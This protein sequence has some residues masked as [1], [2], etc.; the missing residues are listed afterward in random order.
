MRRLLTLGIAVALACVAGAQGVMHGNGDPRTQTPTPN[1]AQSRFYVDDATGKLYQANSGSPCVWT[2]PSATV[3]DPTYAANVAAPP[4]NASGFIA[5]TV[6]TATASIGATTIPVANTSGFSIGQ[7]VIVG[8]GGTSNTKDFAAFISSVSFSSIGLSTTAVSGNLL[9]PTALGGTTGLLAAIQANW[10]VYSVGTTKLVSGA[11]IGATSITLGSAG[12]Y[13]VGQGLLIFGAGT[14]GFN[15]SSLVTKITA[16]A[17]DTVYI[18]DPIAVGVSTGAAVQHD[19]TAAFQAALNLASVTR[20]VRI[21]I[22]DGYYQINGTVNGTTGSILSLPNLDYYPN[23]CTAG[24][25]K[26][27]P[28][29]TIDIGG[30]EPSAQMQSYLSAVTQPH[31]NGVI[32]K[33]SVAGNN[34][35]LGAFNSSASTFANFTNV[36]LVVRNLTLRTYPNPQGMPLNVGKTES[37]QLY[38]FNIDTGETGPTTQPTNSS[39]FAV[40][41]PAAQN[42]GNNVFARGEV[43]GY[44]W[45]LEPGEHSRIEHLRFDNVFW[46]IV[47]NISTYGITGEDIELV[48]CPHGL[49]VF[50]SPAIRNIEISQLNIEHQSSPAW[51]APID[52]ISDSSNQFRGLV[53]IDVQTGQ[54]LTIAGA[55]NLNVVN[56]RNSPSFPLPTETFSALA[57]AHYSVAGNGMRVFLSDG[58]VGASCTGGGTGAW[59]H[60]INGAWVC[61]Q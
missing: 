5:Q 57:N 15:G 30:V 58:T 18:A 23:C 40:V 38:D 21:V 46:P 61:V 45:G 52:D 36:L 3:I 56:M 8:N 29:T 13:A 37:L 42:G 31:T 9:P 4:Y 49:G 19:D 25:S 24:S 34:A 12:G 54:T 11:S 60:R 55:G 39:I 32:I 43:V 27:F 17:G 28:Q 59:A 2:D 16:V 41:G 53:S 51:T 14:G 48:G 1:C 50:G 35:I 7:V 26:W 6:T 22:P 47:G 33:S 20:S 10:L 44:Y